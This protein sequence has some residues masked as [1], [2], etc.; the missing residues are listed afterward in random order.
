[1]IPGTRV[2]TLIEKD[3][4]SIATRIEPDLQQPSWRL[5][6]RG[7]LEARL[8]TTDCCTGGL[9]GRQPEK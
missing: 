1:M 4:V 5:M 8:P 6:Q 3:H 7:A 9:G 2:I